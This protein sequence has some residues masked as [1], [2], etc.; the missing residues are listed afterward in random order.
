MISRAGCGAVEGE[1]GPG[2][3]RRVL[4]VLA[5]SGERGG[6]LVRSSGRVTT[7]LL[8]SPPLTSQQGSPGV[9]T[10][11]TTLM[12]VLTL[13]NKSLMCNSLFVCRNYPFYCPTPYTY[14]MPSRAALASIY[15]KWT[16]CLCV[17]PLQDSLGTAGP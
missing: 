7:S 17:V 16:E 13:L 2:V 1:E 5:G 14:M 6:G 12:D 15:I 4:G 8:H 11:L 10:S 9:R 3:W